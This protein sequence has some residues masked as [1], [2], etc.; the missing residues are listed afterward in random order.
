MKIETLLTQRLQ[1]QTLTERMAMNLDMFFDVKQGQVGALDSPAGPIDSLTVR[2]IHPPVLSIHSLCGRFARR[3]YRFTHCAV[4]SPAVLI[5]SLGVRVTLFTDGGSHAFLNPMAAEDRL[6]L[7]PSV[8]S[9][10]HQ[11]SILG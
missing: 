8:L 9:F 7:P 5:D 2:S 10:R 6:F 3:S 1:L 4:Y 11:P